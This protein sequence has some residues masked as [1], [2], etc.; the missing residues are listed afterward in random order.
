LAASGAR[1]ER[2]MGFIEKMV[3]K[4]MQAGPMPEKRKLPGFVKLKSKEASQGEEGD[5]MPEKCPRTAD[6]DNISNAD[7]PAAQ[8]DAASSANGAA[9]AA[10]AGPSGGMGL[11][12]YDSDSEEDA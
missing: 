8:G 12:G 4:P 2:K 6:A 5:E 10:A 11:V 9:S 7:K 1:I 3:P